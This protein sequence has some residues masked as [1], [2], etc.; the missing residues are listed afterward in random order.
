MLAAFIY[1]PLARA[2]LLLEKLYKP[3]PNWPLFYYRNKSFYI[4]RTDALDRF[5][6]RLEQRFTK[7]EIETMLTDACFE[8]INF[9][10]SAPFWCASGIK[11]SGD[12]PAYSTTD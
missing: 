11:K 4:L 2:A 9:S 3:L 7:A 5:G 12:S 1:W 10:D 6:T 8:N